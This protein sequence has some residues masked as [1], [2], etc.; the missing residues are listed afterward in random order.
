VLS[1]EHGNIEHIEQN[2]IICVWGD[3]SVY[4][5][6]NFCGCCWARCDVWRFCWWPNIWLWAESFQVKSRINAHQREEMP[7]ILSPRLKST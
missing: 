2:L 5:K 7:E 1:T 3:N 4:V 6:K